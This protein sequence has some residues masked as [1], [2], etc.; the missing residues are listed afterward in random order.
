[1]QMEH[2]NKEVSGVKSRL[3]TSQFLWPQH[4]MV[5]CTASRRWLEAAPGLDIGI[6]FQSGG[7]LGGHLHNPGVGHDSLDGQPLHGIV[8]QQSGNQVF[9]PSADIRLRGVSVLHLDVVRDYEKNKLLIQMLD[10]GPTWWFIY[11]LAIYCAMNLPV[12]FYG[13]SPHESLPQMGVFQPGIHNKELPNSTGQPCGHVFSLRS[14]LEAGNPAYR[15][16]STA[17]KTENRN[18]RTLCN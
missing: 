11:T 7:F 1:M 16:E 14:S 18:I 12:I 3:C 8:L 15:T 6:I 2:K 13:K 10:T 4:S 5:I 9:R 17:C